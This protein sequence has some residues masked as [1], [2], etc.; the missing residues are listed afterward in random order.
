VG[1]EALSRGQH[2]GHSKRTESTSTPACQQANTD[3]EF[4]MSK[5]ILK[6]FHCVEETN[7]IDSDSPYFLT[8]V[9]D[10]ATGK[11]HLKL[12]RQGNWHN[13]VDSGEI[14]TV[15]ETVADGFDFSPSKTVVLCALVEEDDGLDINANE[16]DMIETAVKNEMQ[17]FINTGST[18]VTNKVRN[19][20]ADRMRSAI[21][22]ATLTAA[23]DRDDIVSV[24]ALKPNG[25]TGE[26]ALVKLAG[27]GGRYRVRYAVA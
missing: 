16:R 18:T 27:D 2:S 9:G 10:I 7:E 19:D 26:Q 24:K 20:M 6:R 22:L 1:P 17:S 14:W 23:G 25:K 13:E 3:Q 15:N 8:F 21:F 4:I 11:T 12:T 5:L